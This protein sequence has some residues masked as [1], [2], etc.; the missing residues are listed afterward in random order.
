MEDATEPLTGKLE[1][2]VERADYYRV[3]AANGCWVGITP[4]G[5]LKID[6]LIESDFVPPTMTHKVQAGRVTL[7]PMP[8]AGEIT[9]RAT[10]RLEGAVL[11]SMVEAKALADLINAKFEIWK[12]VQDGERV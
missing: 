9:V 2:T 11:L 12:K 10:R 3:L 8:D 5:D 7:P 4:R 1:F 6:F